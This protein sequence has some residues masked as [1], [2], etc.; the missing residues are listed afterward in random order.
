MSDD[1]K[2]NHEDSCT[3]IYPPLSVFIPICSISSMLKVYP[4]GIEYATIYRPIS[5]RSVI[6]RGSKIHGSER[7]IEYRSKYLYL[8]S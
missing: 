8:S 7:P 6:S 3:V 1:R 4:S 2:T 5:S